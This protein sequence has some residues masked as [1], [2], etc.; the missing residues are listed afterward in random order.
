[1][2]GRSVWVHDD[3]VLRE[4]KE[5]TGK[6]GS[7]IISI[8]LR[9]LRHVLLDG[10]LALGLVSHFAMVDMGLSNDLYELWRRIKGNEASKA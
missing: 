9:L 4:L 6:P 7:K 10:R 2:L 1:M 8:S 5:A 3:S